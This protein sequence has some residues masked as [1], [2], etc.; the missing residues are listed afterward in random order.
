MFFFS[1]LKRSYVKSETQKI[2][3]VF[4][5]LVAKWAIDWRYSKIAARYALVLGY[6]TTVIGAEDFF[7]SCLKVVQMRLIINKCKKAI[8]ANMQLT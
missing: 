7:T 2:V 6:E 8:H 3:C 1:L 4:T 5:T